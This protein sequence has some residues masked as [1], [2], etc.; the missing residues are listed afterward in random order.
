MKKYHL[1][2]NT[3][4]SNPNVLAVTQ[5]DTNFLALSSMFLV[6]PLHLTHKIGR[7]C[8]LPIK[9]ALLRYREAG[10]HTA[11]NPGHRERPQAATH[12]GQRLAN[13]RA[14]HP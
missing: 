7:V 8:E 11:Q 2:A 3:A 1:A 5:Q 4:Q 9:K 10:F 12:A 13:Y 6:D 14:D